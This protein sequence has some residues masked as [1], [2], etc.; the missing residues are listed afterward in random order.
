MT[1]SGCGVAEA[2]GVVEAWSVSV[3][4]GPVGVACAPVGVDVGV[5]GGLVGVLVRRAER[6]A[7]T[8]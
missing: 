7:E 6:S 3:G 5:E 4:C 8:E 2:A 1:V